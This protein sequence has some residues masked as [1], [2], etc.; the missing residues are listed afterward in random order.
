M[1]STQATHAYG[2][3]SRAEPDLAIIHGETETHYIGA[4]VSGIGFVNVWFPKATTRELTAEERA[5]YRGKVIEV[6][7]MTRPILIDEQPSVTRPNPSS[8]AE[9]ATR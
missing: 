8:T 3:L 6:G 9:E 2:D 4:W 5:H 7:G 1:M